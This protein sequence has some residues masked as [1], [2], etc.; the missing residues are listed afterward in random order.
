MTRPRRPGVFLD[1]DGVLNRVTL[2]DGRPHPP[3]SADQVELLPGVVEACATL[4]QAGAM[5][6][7]VTNQPDIARGRTTIEDVDAIHRV[8]ASQLPV[9][10]FRL[11]PHDDDDGCDCRKPGPGM[12][13][14]AA[15]EHGLDLR[16][17]VIVGD[18]W[19]DVEAG[20]RA[21]CATVFV[22]RSYAERRPEAPDLVV[23]ELYEAVSWI[24]ERW[25]AKT[26]VT[27]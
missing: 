24:L 27:T 1:R 19:R 13:Q 14:A 20:A 16:L 7:V 11:C 18:R 22:D 5:L 10:E 26:W 21:G 9:D 3:A 15:A 4:K 23:S 17:S 25:R 6:V 2:V 8:L 12:I